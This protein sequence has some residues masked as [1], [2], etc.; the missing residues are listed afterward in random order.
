MSQKVSSTS[1]STLDPASSSISTAFIH[2]L[3]PGLEALE[4]P[5]LAEGWSEYPYALALCLLSIF[6]IFIIELI[7]FR[8]GT[9][10][11]SKVGVVHDAH[12]HNLGGH[13][14]HGPEGVYE[15]GEAPPVKRETSSSDVESAKSHEFEDSLSTHIIGVAILEFGVV[16]HSILIGLTLAVDEDFKILFVVL[17]FHQ[18]FEGLGLGARLAYLQLPKR[19]GWVPV[20]GAILYGLTTPIGIAAG[21]G[22]RSSYNPGSTTA[23]IVSGVM[24]SISAGILVYTGLVELFAHEF[25]FNKAMMK[26]SN[27]RLAYAVGSIVSLLAMAEEVPKPT[28]PPAD[29]PQSQMPPGMVMGPDGK[30]C[31]ICTAFRNWTPGKTNYTEPDSD[32]NSRATSKAGNP[33]AASA[34]EKL[35]SRVAGSPLPSFAGVAGTTTTPLTTASRPD[36]PPPGCPPDVEQLGRATW[37]FLH[38]TAA[39]YPDKPTPT[40]R[41]NMLMLLRSLPILYPCTWCAQDFGRDIEQNPPDVSSRVAL[42]RWLCERHNHVNKKLGKEMFDCAKVDERW[43]DGPADGSC[44]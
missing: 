32:R 40:Q 2:L 21:L 20:A 23:S 25:L 39:Y 7:A 6:A 4:S 19:F 28:S 24:D 42:S 5:C 31:K 44:D 13:A 12:G 33:P 8:W 34:V 10:K 9:A 15:S 22:V 17:V 41:A 43:K 16:L 14:A 1:R 35:K 27:G 11:L 18:T 3:A 38:A 26:A 30:P 29:R 36:E 37:T